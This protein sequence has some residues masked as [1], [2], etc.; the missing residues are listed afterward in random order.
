MHTKI[1]TVKAVW[2]F[3]HVLTPMSHL[4]NLPIKTASLQFQACR[5][6]RVSVKK[7]VF[8]LPASLL[9]TIILYNFLFQKRNNNVQNRMRTKTNKCSA[10]SLSHFLGFLHLQEQ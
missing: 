8:C 2:S 3:L 4:L 5:V 7:T 9:M 1:A 6:N 10:E